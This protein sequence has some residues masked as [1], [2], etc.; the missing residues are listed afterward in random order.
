MSY[1]VGDLPQVKVVWT[2][3][4]GVA[5]DTATTLTVTAPD[6]TVTTPA[7]THGA[8]GTYT[9]TFSVLQAG[10]YVYRFVTA[11][12][13]TAAQE[14]QIE[15]RPS[16]ARLI[17]LDAAKKQINASGLLDDDELRDYLDAVDDIVASKC[18][19]MVRRS[20]VETVLPT[21]G[22]IALSN[23]P[24]ISITSITAVQTG[25]PVPLVSDLVVDGPVGLL[26]PARGYYRWWG[27]L[28]ITYVAGRAVI[29]AAVNMAARII[30][31]NLWDTQHNRSG[32]RPNYGDDATPGMGFA[33]PKRAAE[34]LAQYDS[35]SVA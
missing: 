6:G 13:L 33:I 10:T 34:L 16:G 29:P 32:G 7:V 17:S 30:L 3:L 31:Q 11:D 5:T 28:T 9:A 21:G 18:G 8:T 35:P 27:A 25:F 23:P 14:S 24:V 4:S 15:V 12:V 1:D 2:N 20:Y 19:A 26:Y 22:I